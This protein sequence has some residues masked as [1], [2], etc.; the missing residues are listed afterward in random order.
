MSALG[1]TRVV[2][3]YGRFDLAGHTY[4]VMEYCPY[5]T[6]ADHLI[7]TGRM[8]YAAGKSIAFAFRFI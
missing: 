4:L 2:H 8:S 3:Y 1:F 7:R 5:G 6:L